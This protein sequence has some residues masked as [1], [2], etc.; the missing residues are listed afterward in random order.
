MPGSACQVLYDVLRLLGVGVTSEQCLSLL[1]L[2]VDRDPESKTPPPDTPESE[3]RCRVWWL[4]LELDIQ[5]SMHVGRPLAAQVKLGINRPTFSGVEG[6]YKDLEQSRLDFTQYALEVLDELGAYET[7]IGD[8]TYESLVELTKLDRLQRMETR[9]P[10]IPKDFEYDEQ[11]LIAVGDH[12]V[13]LLA[14]KMMLCC[15]LAKAAQKQRGSF[16]VFQKDDQKGDIKPSAAKAGRPRG[17]HREE[18]YPHQSAIYDS[19]RSIVESFAKVASIDIYDQYANWNRFFDAYCAASILAIAALRDETRL[20][21]DISMIM[22]MSSLLQ[23]ISNRN[24][25]CHIATVAARRIAQLLDDIQKDSTAAKVQASRADQAV[26]SSSVKAK[27]KRTHSGEKTPIT[28]SAEATPKRK[29]KTDDFETSSSQGVKRTKPD[30]ASTHQERPHEEGGNDTV[31]YA[32]GPQYYGAG[33]AF[34]GQMLSGYPEYGDIA[35]S[36]S[37][38]F[39]T[40]T[41]QAHYS[42]Y[43]PYDGQLYVNQTGV[44][45]SWF[46]PPLAHPPVPYQEID[47]WVLPTYPTN[48]EWQH[49]MTSASH[50]NIDPGLAGQVELSTQVSGQ[51]GQ[52][53]YFP[54]STMSVPTTPTQQYPFNISGHF[55]GTEPAVSEDHRAPGSGHADYRGTVAAQE[56]SPWDWVQHQQSLMRRSSATAVQTTRA[57]D[58]PAYYAN[59]TYFQAYEIPTTTGQWG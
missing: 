57:P 51:H 4:I 18:A 29:R 36:T 52:R 1:T 59:T 32:P 13:E 40:G 55:A 26:P 8:R 37:T 7:D 10:Q 3:F 35:T 48:E 42:P 6:V 43:M 49:H 16:T 2:T 19:A 14:F 33:E 56:E 53:S 58:E 15:T 38:S 30:P 17:I 25:H 20:Q 54:H 31:M 44:S 11:L 27:L 39:D 23:T 12:K 28:E 46:H 34:Q 41:S 5:I 22:T 9:L 24:Q 21:S 45:R 47:A 50:S